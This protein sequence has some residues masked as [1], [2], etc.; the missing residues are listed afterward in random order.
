MRGVLQVSRSFDFLV[1]S[2]VGDDAK[3]G[4]RNNFLIRL[5]PRE[6]EAPAEPS[7]LAA[8]RELRSPGNGDTGFETFLRAAGCRRQT[9]T[10]EV[11]FIR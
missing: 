11:G 8:Q 10:E 7:R 4:L 5:R 2:F 9:W 1:H 3:G 6:G